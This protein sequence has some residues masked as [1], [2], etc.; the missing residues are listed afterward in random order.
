MAA[1]FWTSSHAG[2]L[3]SKERLQASHARDRA[4]GLSEQQIQ[5]LNIFHVH[6]ALVQPLHMKRERLLLQ[7]VRHDLLEEARLPMR[8]SSGLHAHADISDLAR[9]L[10]LMVRQR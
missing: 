3:Q 7:F 9:A 4:M 5:D 8:A 2:L 6:C 1:S 10:Q